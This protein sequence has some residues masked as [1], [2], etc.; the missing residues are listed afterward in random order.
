MYL[1]SLHGQGDVVLARLQRGADRVQGGDEVVAGRAVEQRQHRG[2][3]PRHDLHRRDDVL[4]VGDLHAEHRLLGGRGAH[5]ERDD[6]HGPAA[7]APAVQLGHRRLHL[8]R[9]APVV[10]DAG[11]GLQQRADEG[12][13]LDPRDVVGV[14]GGPERVRL[15][16]RAGRTC[17]PRRGGSSPVPTPP[18]T[19]R[20]TR[21]GPAWSAPPPPAPRTAG[22]RSRSGRRRSLARSL[23]SSRAASY[24]AG[25]TDPTSGTL[26]PTRAGTGG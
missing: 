13:L 25:R 20:T 26:T 22:A 8:G 3:H 18:R 2:A 7:H 21:S 6:V 23:R 9:V 15:R 24:L 16:R 10:G 17:P 19:R 12:A 5:A 14:G 1:V 4:G 11:V